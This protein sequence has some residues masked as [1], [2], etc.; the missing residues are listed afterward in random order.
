MHGKEAI[1]F[2]ND[3]FYPAF[4]CRDIEAMSYLWAQTDD[5]SVIHPG[6][7]AFVRSGGG[8]LSSW[9]GIVSEGD[10]PSIECREP[11]L[12]LRNDCATMIF[13]L[14][15]MDSFLLQPISL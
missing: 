14:I 5:V 4:S 11:H 10:F 8:F 15:L 12:F 3:A 13:F 6:W 9:A 2:N 7:G 1:L